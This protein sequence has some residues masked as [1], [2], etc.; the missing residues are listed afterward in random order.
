MK[1]I[2]TVSDNYGMLFNHRRVSRDKAVTEDILKM[3]GDTP[4][5]ISSFSSVLFEGYDKVIT[6]D[7]FLEHA[8]NDSY[9]FV[10]NQ[11]LSAFSNQIDTFIIYHWNRNYPFDTTFN[12][13]LL[14]GFDMIESVEFSGNSH[15]TITKTIYQRNALTLA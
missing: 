5:Y 15:E 3:I 6:D 14:N 8:Q 9:C 2:L 12:P 7:S 4:L 11:D 10:E 1:I 13:E